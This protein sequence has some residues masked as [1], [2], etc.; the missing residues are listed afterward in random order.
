MVQ[1]FIYI[2][3]NKKSFGY[4]FG[5]IYTLLTVTSTVVLSILKLIGAV[6]LSWVM[7]TAPVWLSLICALILLGV[8][9]AFV[10]LFKNDIWKN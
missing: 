3:E 10:L 5:L 8:A 2:M 9:A 4:W 7:I 6:D 1:S